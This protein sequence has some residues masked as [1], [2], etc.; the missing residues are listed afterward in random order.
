MSKRLKAMY[1]RRQAES[2]REAFDQIPAGILVWSRDGRII[3]ANRRAE[4]ILKRELSGVLKDAVK[5]RDGFMEAVTAVAGSPKPITR[6]STVI[7]LDGEP[8][9]IGYSGAPLSEGK[10]FVLLFQDISQVV[11]T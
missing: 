1:W 7:N 2:L 4:G 3:R 9:T 10:S 6:R 5:G 8:R 11:S